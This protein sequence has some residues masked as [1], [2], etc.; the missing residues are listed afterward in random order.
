MLE[1]RLAALAA[2][3]PAAVR[4]GRAGL[5]I[6]PTAGRAARVVGRARPAA[7]GI[8]AAGRLRGG[9]GGQR[10]PAR[11][12]RLQAPPHAGPLADPRAAAELPA[13][14]PGRGA[15]STGSSSS[16]AS[17][18]TRVRVHAAARPSRWASC[19][20][21]A[22]WWWVHAAVARGRVP[23][24]LHPLQLPGGAPAGRRRAHRGQRQR[25]GHERDAQRGQGGGGSRLRARLRR[26]ARLA[27]LAR[28][29]DG[30]RRVLPER[31][32]PPS[33]CS[34]TCT[35]CGS[36]SGAARASPPARARSCPWPRRPRWRALV[37]F[38]VVPPLTRYVSLGS[39]VGARRSAALAFL[40]GRA[41]ADPAGRRPL[42]AALIVVKHRENI[43]APRQRDGAPHGRAGAMTLRIAVVGGGA[44]GTALAV[45]PRPRRARRPAVGA[46]PRARRRRSPRGRNAALPARRRAPAGSPPTTDLAARGRGRRAG[47]RGRPLGV[48]P[49]HLPR[50]ARRAAPRTPIVVSATK[51][52]ELDTAAAHDARSPRRSCPAG[53]LAVLSG[54]SFAPRS[55]PGQ[56]TA[57]VVASRDARRR[58]GAC[59]GPSPR[60]PSAPTR[61]TTWSGVE[62]GGRAQERDRHRGRDRGRPRLRAQHRGRPH[63]P[64]PR[65]DDPPRRGAGRAA[66]HPGRPG[67][68]RRPRA[69]LHRRPLPQPAPSARPS[70]AGRRVARGPG[71]AAGRWWRA[72]AR[73][74]PPAPWPARAGIEMPIAPR[75]G[76]C[77][78]RAS[79][80]REA[81]TS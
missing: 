20:G 7:R 21:M 28:A 48:L 58:R 43:R 26:R 47:R 69:H 5:G 16:A 13:G 73:P 74:S 53:A 45:A 41:A 1:P 6:F 62:L 17:S 4:A 67:R 44:W 56:P 2:R 59:S 24:G 10:L 18:G 51:G 52:L 46:R 27:T 29:R 15:C 40:L 11:A 35:R 76:P 32:P 54:P 50:A 30:G 42:V 64:R 38:A 23:A 79:P 81:S 61:A 77:S 39:I 65:R 37:A 36:A 55:R 68:P 80:P 60:A 9:R 25:G 63:H 66:G 70:G 3:L 8:D 12:P 49:R 22:P 31:W 72:S 14:R 71:A 34:G 75:C 19:S 57:V 33:P 78:T